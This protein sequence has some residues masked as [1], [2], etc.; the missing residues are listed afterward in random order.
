[1]DTQDSNGLNSKLNRRPSGG[2]Q[3]F[4]QKRWQRGSKSQYGM[5]DSMDTQDTLDSSLSMGKILTAGKDGLMDSTDDPPD[6]NAMDTSGASELEARSP[7][8]RGHPG[9]LTT[10][11]PT[12]LDGH[13]PLDDDGVHLID[14]GADGE[15]LQR[16]ELAGSRLRSR[17]RTPSPPNIDDIMGTMPTLPRRGSRSAMSDMG[18]PPYRQPSLRAPQQPSIRSQPASRQASLHS[19]TPPLPSQPP[20]ATH[21]RP[22]SSHASSQ[23]S[24][25]PRTPPIPTPHSM[26][27]SSSHRS[28][29]TPPKM[30]ADLGVQTSDEED[31]TI[32]PP[33]PEET[34]IDD[35]LPLSPPAPGEYRSDDDDDDDI[36]FGRSELK[37]TRV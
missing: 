17:S 13:M 7:S 28:I 20:S 25:R 36:P 5:G 18:G 8:P 1:M 29:P 30:T 34:D 3:R 37:S 14:F 35:V 12:P 2:R 26:S 11:S 6:N 4:R 24:S 21:S 33:P 16:D 23:T 9:A 32:P 19:R 15:P 10:S 31:E 22:A 27:R